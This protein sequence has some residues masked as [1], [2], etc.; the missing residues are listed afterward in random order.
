[1]VLLTIDTSINLELA[2]NAT[3]IPFL[4]AVKLNNEQELF[5]CPVIG[6]DKTLLE[7]E[8]C[9]Q[10]YLSYKTKSI[11]IEFLGIE[12]YFVPTKTE[13]DGTD[14]RLIKMLA[15]K[16]SFIPRVVIPSSF[17]AA[18]SLVCNQ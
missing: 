2:T 12:P 1:M 6:L 17:A 15:D 8:M 10:S 9:R 16:L 14:M 13:I 5:I 11:R 4:L 7:R 18:D 3:K